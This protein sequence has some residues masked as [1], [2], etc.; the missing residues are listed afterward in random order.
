MP[1]PPTLCRALLYCA[2]AGIGAAACARDGDALPPA[3]SVL[4]AVSV[5]E[6]PLPGAALPGA[7]RQRA[8]HALSFATDAPK[9]FLRGLGIDATEC[10]LRLR[11]PSRIAAPAVGARLRLDVQAQAGLGCK[12]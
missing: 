6:L 1:Q 2:L 12:F 4:E 10:S 5:V 3:R 7:A 11:L 9:P 8:H